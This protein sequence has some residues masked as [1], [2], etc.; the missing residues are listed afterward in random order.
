MPKITFIV[1]TDPT[2]EGAKFAKEVPV[3]VLGGSDPIAMAELSIEGPIIKATADIDKRWH[4]FFPGVGIYQA[5]HT[6][7]KGN[8]TYDVPV[9]HQI[10]L[11]LLVGPDPNVKCIKD[12]VKEK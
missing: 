4:V 8:V 12:Q 7:D 1:S 5:K 11:G 2:L 6:D 10:G 3:K 9:I